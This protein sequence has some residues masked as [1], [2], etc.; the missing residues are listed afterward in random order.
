MIALAGCSS[1][2]D[3]GSASTTVAA[4]VP[5]TTQTTTQTTGNQDQSSISG[6]TSGDQSNTV[7][8]ANAVGTSVANNQITLDSEIGAA[9]NLTE[10]A[11][12]VVSGE[13]DNGFIRT[14][15]EQHPGDAETV[16]RNTSEVT[17]QFSG[18]PASFNN[19]T[20]PSDE[21][22]VTDGCNPASNGCQIL[23]ATFGFDNGPVEQ[24]FGASNTGS[25][26]EEIAT[27]DGVEVTQETFNPNERVNIESTRVQI[28]GPEREIFLN[29]AVLAKYTEGSTSFFFD[30]ESDQESDERIDFE[31]NG[32]AFA[33]IDPT[34]QADLDSLKQNNIRASYDSIVDYTITRIENGTTM[35]D[36]GGTRHSLVADFGNGTVTGEI[37]NLSTFDNINNATNTNLDVVLNANIAGNTFEGTSNL[38]QTNGN[39]IAGSTGVSR[40]AFAGS[41]AQEAVGVFQTQ[42]TLNGVETT[43]QGAFGGDRLQSVTE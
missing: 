14:F 3:D 37:I 8:V 42:G 27:Q 11:Y 5:A 25:F 28:L 39:E 18:A 6:D 23:T 29:H 26:R 30:V 35:I 13:I 2:G 41:Q 1:S 43:V 22:I 32:Y 40:G 36:G 33:V 31:N 20:I 10:T 7:V 38:R 15:V 9:V 34:S 4:V 21:F 16:W 19:V 24:Q 17:I 12:E